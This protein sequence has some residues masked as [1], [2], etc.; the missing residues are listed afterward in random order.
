MSNEDKVGT[1]ALSA[2]FADEYDA[3]AAAHA[4]MDAGIPKDAITMTPGNRPDTSPID[5]IGFLD[6]LTG[7]FFH[8]EQRSAYAAALERGGTLVT[9]QEMNEEQHNIAL[10]ILTEK[11]QIELDERESSN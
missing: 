9:V 7:I 10:P 2:F 5:H 6:A 8:E 11:G 1:L 4:L 3:E